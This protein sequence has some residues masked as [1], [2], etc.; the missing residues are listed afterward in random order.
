MRK[1][2]IPAFLLLT[3]LFSVLLPF[4]ACAEASPRPILYTYY[5]QMGWG[6][7]LEI[8]YLDSDGNL[9]AL[10]GYEST[11]HWPYKTEE[12]LQF[13]AENSFENIGRLK[14]DDLFDLKSLVNAVQE[15]DEPS[16]PAA[17]DAGTEETYAVRY[18]RDG[19][20]EA[21]LLG[22]SGDDVFENTDPNAQGLYLAARRLFPGVIAYGG[23]MGPA[24]FIPKDLVGFCGLG[25]LSGAAV[26]ASYNDCE[27]GPSEIPL[28]REQQKQILDTVRSTVVTG[29]V[30]AC[31]TTGGFRSYDFFRGDQYLG[32]INIYNDLLYCSDG[33]YS[34][35]RKN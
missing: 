25:S 30:S 4:S 21:I 10:D 33:M 29:K 27:S 14:F 35:E 15:S 23:S 9:W 26:R 19:N 2:V 7:R 18:D 12:Q 3:F 17:C 5:L 20:A 8:A 24:G 1:T 16:Y 31:V 13:L 11:L 6:D 28:S 32:C 34:I 22:M